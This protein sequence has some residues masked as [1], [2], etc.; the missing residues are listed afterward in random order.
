MGTS[1]E[2]TA[3][4]DRTFDG[5]ESF[6]RNVGRVLGVDVDEPAPGEA[7]SAPVQIPGI[8]TT[9]IPLAP[10][11]PM[12][13]LPAKPAIALPPAGGT[14]VVPSPWKIIPLR[15]S[16]GGTAYAVTDG[17]RGALAPT[18]QAADALLAM[19]ASGVVS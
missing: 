12:R 14:G 8:S 17:E 2:M 16:D 3:A 1:D 15:T 5:A 9:T 4:I 10:V 18:R 6:V 13:T 11:V 19:L 7:A